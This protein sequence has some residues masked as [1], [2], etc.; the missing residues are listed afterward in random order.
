VISAIGRIGATAPDDD[1]PLCHTPV[2]VHSWHGWHRDVDTL[3]TYLANR[4]ESRW[5]LYAAS[6]YDFSVGLF[7]LWRSGKTPVIPPLNTSGIVETLAPHVDCLLGE[8]PLAESIIRDA[9]AAPAAGTPRSVDP[10]AQLVMFTSGSSGE[11]KAIRKNIAQLDAEVATLESLWGPRLDQ[12]VILATV[13]HQHIYGLLFKVLWPLAA[14]RQFY[15]STV[16]DPQTLVALSTRH[17]RTVWVTSPAFLKRMPTDIFDSNADA[18]VTLFSSGGLL[19]A[20]I[21]HRIGRHMSEP[22][23]E[24]YGSTETGGIAYRQQRPP[25]NDTPWIPLPGVAVD[26]NSDG[27]L[28]VRSPHLPDTAWHLTGDRGTLLSGQRFCLGTRIDRIVK[29]EEKRVSLTA[30]ETELASVAGVAD[31]ACVLRPGRRDMICAVLALDAAGYRDLYADGRRRYIRRLRDTLCARFDRVTLPRKWR[32]VEDLPVNDQGKSTT[33]TL[34][35]LFEPTRIHRLP[36]VTGIN[37]PT[38]HEATLTLFIPRQLIYFDGHFSG[39]PVLPGIAQL[40]WAGHYARQLFGLDFVWRH[41]EAVKFNRIVWPE[42]TVALRLALRDDRRGFQ[43]SY[44]VDG[45]TCSSGRLTQG[46]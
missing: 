3:V 37:C 16:R 38:D 36:V 2:S 13:S 17:R 29:V 44:A 34:I 46:E 35:A 26:T 43:F 4:R 27:Q 15:A 32:F 9:H 25:H 20:P 19:A 33:A 40:F 5:G 41:M 7:A 18:D 10:A 42:S 11:A 28:L 30:M 39:T 45:V 1:R 8:F 14:G 31:A 21:A 12:A 6:T 24:V 22:P 23:I